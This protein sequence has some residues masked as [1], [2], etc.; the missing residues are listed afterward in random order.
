MKQHNREYNRENK[1]SWKLVLWK[2]SYNWY[3]S[4]KTDKEKQNQEINYQ[5]KE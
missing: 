1:S 3:N 2:Y 5:Y 4:S